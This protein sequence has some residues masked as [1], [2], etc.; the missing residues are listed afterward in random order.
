MVR[1]GDRPAPHDTEASPQGRAGAEDVDVLDM[2]HLEPRLGQRRAPCGIQHEAGGVQSFRLE[3]AA[4]LGIV[5]DVDL[6]LAGAG[7]QLLRQRT[8]SIVEFDRAVGIG[9]PDQGQDRVRRL[10]FVAVV[11]ADGDEVVEL[12]VAVHP[13]ALTTGAG[14]GRIRRPEV[15]S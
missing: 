3:E 6:E 1:M 14:P 4:A 7:V 5:I 11:G 13:G 10:G 15:A 8:M 2:H 9:R 12:Q